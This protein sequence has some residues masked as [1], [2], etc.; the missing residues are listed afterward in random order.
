MYRTKIAYLNEFGGLKEQSQISL[1]KSIIWI[2]D[3]LWTTTVVSL[4]IF[5]YCKSSGDF[6]GKKYILPSTK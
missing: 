4:W 1:T 2:Q 3:W 5:I 6:K